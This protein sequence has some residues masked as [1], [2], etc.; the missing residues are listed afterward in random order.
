M[1]GDL[2]WMFEAA[3]RELTLFAAVGILI[4]GIDDLLVDLIWIVRSLWRRLTIY[5]VHPRAST[6]ALV[7]RAPGLLAVFVA[8]W[9]ESAVI[10]PMVRTALARWPGP[11]YR[12]YVG[13]YPNDAA[14]RAVL[15]EIA[16]PR[17]RIV[18]NPA[19]GPTTKADNLNA[20]WRAMLADEA[21]DGQPVK[22]VVLHDAEDVVHPDELHIFDALIERFSLVQ[23]PVLPLIERDRGFWARA[24]SATY[25]DEFAEAHAKQ[26]V[27]REAV[28]AGLPSAGVGCA[29]SRAVLGEIAGAAGTP[30][31]AA[32]VTED[33][34]LGLR[35]RER[36]GRAAFVRLPGRPG[37]RAVA[38]RAHFPDVVEEAVRQK[39][40]WVAGIALSGWRRLG[41]RGGL[42][43]RWM[44]LRDRR[45][46]LA[47][48]VLFTAYLSLAG[49]VAL[50]LLGRPPRL[51]PGIE[52]LIL[53]ATLF[54][55]W[56]VG[57]RAICVGREYGAAEALR[58]VPR[59]VLGNLIAIAA[60]R[61]ALV[62]YLREARGG[63]VFWDKTAHRFPANVSPE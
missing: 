24:V 36:G 31:D 48:L 54:L 42:A 14:T 63:T 1:A 45:A 10:G 12:L 58:S 52:T 18:L 59:M 49:S 39:A 46:I 51:G 38:V 11:G 6:A 30:F 53:I 21:R 27:V 3:H 35:I 15:A 16:D 34:E 61:H 9:K 25:A 29:F 20:M 13:C 33:Y 17:L 47:A 8:A 40:R 28:G 37:G 4:G 60:S 23:L 62:R 43:E 22:A 2:L 57:L 44:R 26:M 7:P 19:D 55:L 41:W 56:R 50:T 5:R 32:S